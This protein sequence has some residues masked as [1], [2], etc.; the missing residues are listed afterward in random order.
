M[1]E[2]LDLSAALKI[3]YVRGNST[4][5]VAVS[6]LFEAYSQFKGR[7]MSSTDLREFAPSVFDSNARP[8]GHSCNCTLHFRIL[9]VLDLAGEIDGAGVRGDPFAVAVSD[10]GA[11]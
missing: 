7:P 3:S 8:A 9:Q 6:D 2:V 5:A 10:G 1:T 4:I 11:A